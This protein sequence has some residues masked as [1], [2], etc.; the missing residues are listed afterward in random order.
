MQAGVVEQSTRETTTAAARRAR[1]ALTRRA[2]QATEDWITALDPPAL[3]EFIVQES[4]ILA[5]ATKRLEALGPTPTTDHE[6]DDWLDV[7][8][9]AA[10]IHRSVSWIRHHRGLPGRR[11][12]R[13]GGRVVW[14]R[15]ALEAWLASHIC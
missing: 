3:L 15:R 11:Q 6:P 2:E 10:L 12:E 7:H 4:A 13:P 5:Q 14:S 8:Q 9:V 1:L